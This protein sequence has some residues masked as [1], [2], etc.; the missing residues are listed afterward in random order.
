M[1]KTETKRLRESPLIL[2]KLYDKRWNSK[3]C[4][5]QR[6]K[7]IPSVQRK[8]FSYEHAHCSNFSCILGLKAL[9]QNCSNNCF[10]LCQT[11]VPWLNLWKYLLMEV[12]TILLVSAVW[13]RYKIFCRI[14]VFSAKLRDLKM[15]QDSLL[16][17]CCQWSHK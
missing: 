8:T 4:L 15:Q 2:Q 16:Q 13:S 12:Y 17:F 11:N 1:S 14:R 10:K 3:K 6:N 7:M 5:P 9:M